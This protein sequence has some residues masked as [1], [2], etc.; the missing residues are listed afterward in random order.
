MNPSRVSLE[1]QQRLYATS[2]DHVRGE[3]M[4]EADALRYYAAYCDFVAKSSGQTQGRL[5][6]VGCGNGWSSYAFARR[7]YDVTGTD[8]NPARFEPPP[9]EGLHL[10]QGSALDLPFPAASFDLVAAYTV[11]EHVP[12]PEAMLREM[13]RVTRP[14]GTVTI[15]SPHLLSPLASLRV[16]FKHSWRHRS[17]KEIFVRSPRMP[18]H[19]PGNTLPEGVATFFGNIGRMMAKLLSR[20][21]SF[22]MREP[23]LRPP[24]FADNDACY[25]CNP[26]DLVK[27]FRSR[28]CHI[29][30]NGDFGRPPLSWLM[31]SVFVTAITPDRD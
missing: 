29:L 3:G 10:Q 9:H 25:L 30:R 6:D 14:G 4:N 8:L 28:G 19:P 27:Y 21:P 24:L 13:I 12:D 15:V 2:G 1:E 16:V 31:S 11:I 22:T 17:A 7:G 5:L 23:D 26:I 20:R 18:R